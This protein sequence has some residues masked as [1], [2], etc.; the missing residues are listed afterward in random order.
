MCA[1]DLPDCIHSQDNLQREHAMSFPTSVEETESGHL[2]HFAKH[3]TVQ[4]IVQ[5]RFNIRPKGSAI[6]L[7]SLTLL[8][9]LH[10]NSFPSCHYSMLLNIKKES[11][12]KTKGQ[13]MEISTGIMP[14]FALCDLV[15]KGMNSAL[16]HFFS[17]M[18]HV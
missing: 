7:P 15:Y 14:N 5:I 16:S 12:R 13:R 6:D 2:S 11:S 9:A 10:L 18:V 8:P 17:L 4:E 3:T 1:C